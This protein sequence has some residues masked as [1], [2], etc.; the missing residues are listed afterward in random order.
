MADVKVQSLSIDPGC[1]HEL[2]DGST[3]LD[4][5]LIKVQFLDPSNGEA[6]PIDLAQALLEYSAEVQEQLEEMSD[7]EPDWTAPK[8]ESFKWDDCICEIR[9]TVGPTYRVRESVDCPIPGHGEG[10]DE[11]YS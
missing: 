9:Q 10:T 5:D 4:P 2:R 1:E 6:T 11:E 7:S 8:P 3:C